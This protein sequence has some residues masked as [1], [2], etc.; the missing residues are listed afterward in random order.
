MHIELPQPKLEITFKGCL[1]GMQL[2]STIE[3]Y[4]RNKQTAFP[5]RILHFNQCDPLPPP[6]KKTKLI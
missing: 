4:I 6:Q 2:L 5:A 1:K 3:F